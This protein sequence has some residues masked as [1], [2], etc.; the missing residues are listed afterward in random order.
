[1]R[2]FWDYPYGVLVDCQTDGLRYMLDRVSYW[3]NSGWAYEVWGSSIIHV[4]FN[5]KDEAVYFAFM[6]DGVAFT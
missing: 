1:M 2:E 4:R 5:D 3:G 6:N